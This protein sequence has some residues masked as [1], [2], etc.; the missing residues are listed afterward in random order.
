M[1]PSNNK[2]SGRK[3]KWRGSVFLGNIPIGAD[4]V[5]ATIVDVAVVVTGRTMVAPVDPCSVD[6]EGCDVPVRDK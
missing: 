1:S 2:E 5:A 3:N 4:C 6:A